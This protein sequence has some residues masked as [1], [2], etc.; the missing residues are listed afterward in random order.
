MQLMNQFHR[1]FRELFRAYGEICC[2][3]RIQSL[4]GPLAS[5]GSGC[6]K[7]LRAVTGLGF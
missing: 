6:S 2:N 1:Q 7:F 5:S 4:D 3:D